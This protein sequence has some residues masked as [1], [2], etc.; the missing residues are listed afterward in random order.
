MAALPNCQPKLETFTS[1][2]AQF[3]G[4]RARALH[5]SRCFKR[6]YL[7]DRDA[8][9]GKTLCLA[10]LLTQSIGVI[11]RIERRF[12][13]SVMAMLFASTPR[14]FNLVSRREA[15]G[16]AIT[17]ILAI[18]AVAYA[19][20]PSSGPAPA[21]QGWT[22]HLLT[23]ASNGTVQTEPMSSSSLV[24][25]KS[26]LILPPPPP[27]PVVRARNSCDSA[28][29]LCVVR[30]LA[31]MA[32][33]PKRQMALNDSQQGGRLPPVL[34]PI[35]DKSS[36]GAKPASADTKGF[37]LNPLNHIPDMS[38]IGRPFAAAGQAVSG[39]IKWL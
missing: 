25:P 32:L 37:S 6:G 33:P 27:K 16:A 23:A 22:G 3:I 31:V 1:Q 24:V 9:P 26:A 17:V 28:D 10:V 13:G 38:A 20:R 29:R 5:L 19:H 34:G 30:P 7:R 2:H 11:E 36:R 12:R 8:V 21:E 4:F 15:V 39:W 35:P 18:S 14:V